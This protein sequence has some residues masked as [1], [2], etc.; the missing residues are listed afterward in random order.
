MSHSRLSL[1]VEDYGLSLPSDGRIA[2][3]APRV[4]YDLNALPR[5]QVHVVQ[6]LKPDFDAFSD[7][8]YEAA[9]VEDGTYKA[10]VV[11]LPRAKALAR[12][13]IARATACADPVIVEGQK[14]DG[15]GGLY[16]E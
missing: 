6:H 7:A 13:L 10:A 3:F 12:D 9:V 5:T 14:P 1:A 11:V 4:G 8:G 16:K 15:V 2:V